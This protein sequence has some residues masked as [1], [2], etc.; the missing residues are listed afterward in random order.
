MRFFRLILLCLLCPVITWAQGQIVT[1]KVVRNDTKS[2]V[3]GANVFF[4]NSSYGTSTAADGT[5]KLNDVLPGQYTLV[6]NH[7]GY[8]DYTLTIL[9]AKEPLKLTIDMA[10][11]S[12]VLRQVT[13]S[14]RADWKRNFEQF[15]KEFIGTDENA[16]LCEIINPSILDF[17]YYKTQ[18]VLL[19]SATQ[20]LIVENRALGYRIK[21]LLDTFRS[22][23]INNLLITGGQRVFEELPGTKV[24]QKQWRI[25]RNLA[26]YG[27][28]MHFY[29]SLYK[30]RLAEEGFEIHRYTRYLNPNRPSDEVILRNYERY[31]SMG[32]ADSANK[33]AGVERMSKYY[34]EMFENEQWLV[35]EVL[36]RTPQP[37]IFAF[38][39][40]DC[41][42]VQYIKKRDD[43]FYKDIYLP[44]NVPN[45]E[46]SIL[47][48]MTKERVCFFDMNGILVGNAPL[49]EGTWSKARLSQQLPVDYQPTPEDMPV[50]SVVL[51]KN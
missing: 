45:Y 2:P 37:G 36:G 38:T 32:R 50:Q 51:K 17:T 1:G 10:P 34:H 16:K 12:I 18:K 44:L 15:R 3:A 22:D 35:S 28:P 8:A 4:N 30:D 27:S 42:C 41:M 25:N 33:W 20:F 9:V 11:K 29:R 21:F 7:L 24:Q 19:A 49:Y 26:Y 43:T 31:K 48:F 5:F 39:F 40:P 46:T 47:T 6:I 23:G 14:T 13:I